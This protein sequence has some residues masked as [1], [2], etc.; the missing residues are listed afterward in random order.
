MRLL[1]LRRNLLGWA[2]AALAA[3]PPSALAEV[4]DRTVQ[5]SVS[6]QVTRLTPTVFST[7]LDQRNAVTG[8]VGDLDGDGDLDALILHRVVEE[9]S[10]LWINDGAGAFTDEAAARLPTLPPGET[11][12]VVVADLDGD[13]DLDAYLGRST[14]D[15]VWINDGAGHFSDATASWLAAGWGGSSDLASADVT[16]DGRPDLVAVQ[17]GAVRVLENVRGTALNE[18]SVQVGAPTDGVVA[19]ALSDVD[20]DGDAD[21][22]SAGPA[23]FQVWLND[24]PRLRALTPIANPSQQRV[25]GLAAA[26]VS[27]D[28]LPDLLIARYDQPVVLTSRGAGQFALAFLPVRVLANTVKAADVDGDGRQD[29]FFAAAGA[30]VLLFNGGAGSWLTRTGWLPLEAEAG[31]WAALA[32]FN[33]DHL[34]DLFVANDGQDQLYLQ[35]PAP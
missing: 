14:Q 21:L 25:T 3:L 24:R 22:V 8:A 11:W 13:G 12:S 2:A 6:A 31:R 29:A 7:A 19:V 34:T 9:A 30:D 4:L 20:A 5:V 35:R 32:D 15:A 17:G 10:Y 26:D 18:I 1:R 28:G 23:N 33:G 27:G 16:G